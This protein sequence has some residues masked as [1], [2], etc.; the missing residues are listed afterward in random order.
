[1]EPAPRRLLDIPPSYWP[2]GKLIYALKAYGAIY[3]QQ[4]KGI[5]HNFFITIPCKLQGHW[6]TNCIFIAHFLIILLDVPTVNLWSF[7]LFSLFW[8]YSSTI[9]SRSML[10][11]PHI[12]R[13]R[14]TSIRRSFEYFWKVLVYEYIYTASLLWCGRKHT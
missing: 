2:T 4:K 13:Y 10:Y 3:L 8:C 11:F 7:S 5:L 12:Q 9:I 14:S 6:P 1:M